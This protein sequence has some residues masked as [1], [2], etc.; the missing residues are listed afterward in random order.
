MSLDEG[1]SEKTVDEEVKS[2]EEHEEIREKLPKTARASITLLSLLFTTVFIGA[3]LFLFI[4]DTLIPPALREYVPFFTMV[5]KS[6]ESFAGKKS[7]EIVEVTKELEELKMKEQ[8]VKKNYPLRRGLGQALTMG[9]TPIIIIVI[10][11]AIVGE[12]MNIINEINNWFVITMQWNIPEFLIGLLLGTLMLAVSWVATIFGPIYVVFHNTSKILLRLGAYRYAAI[13]QDLENLFALPYFAAKSSF[14]IFDA[15][16]ISSETLEEFKLDIKEELD[17]MKEKVQGLLALDVKH[18][19]ARSKEILE[20]LLKEVE[21]PLEK[22]DLTKVTDQTAR[23]FSLLIWSKESS[24]LPW[25]HK[26]ALERFTIRNKISEDDA[27]IAFR[28]VIEKVESGEIDDHMYKSVILSGALKGIMQQQEIYD[29]KM[30][31]DDYNKLAVA[32]SLGAQQYICDTYKP[33]NKYLKV[34]QQ[35][36]FFFLALILPVLVIIY[37]LIMYVKHILFFLFKSIF[38][39][40]TLKLPQTIARRYKELNT[41]F[42]DTF[43]NLKAKGEKPNIRKEHDLRFRKFFAKL[44]KGILKFLFGLLKLIL[45]WPLWKS[46]YKRIKRIIESRKEENRNKR[47]FEKEITTETLVSMYKEVYEKF[48]VSSIV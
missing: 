24:I 23:T 13:Y 43:H 19:P 10:P 16:P 46:L 38:S 17:E 21:I 41:I 34:L 6:T 5:R 15:P 39:K 26:E 33:M 25:R 18:V 42:T 4:F 8:R 2:D 3:K 45:F 12:R 7:K 37:A 1:N 32:L 22:L 47:K 36:G 30:S 20:K 27:V 44:G 11:T 35:I 14:S 31:Y 28:T 29:Q 48:V 9:L 40:K